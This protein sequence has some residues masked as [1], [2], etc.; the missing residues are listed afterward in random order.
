LQLES[1]DVGEFGMNTPA[2]VCLDTI[3]PGPSV[4]SFDDLEL[5]ADEVWN[6]SDGSNGFTS[7]TVSFSNNYNAE[8]DSW[9]GFA[10]SNQTDTTLEGLDGQYTAIAGGG[11]AGT[12]NYA[13]AYVGWAEPPTMTVL[14]PQVLEGLYVTNTNYAYYAMR[15][16][17]AF[18]K[19][20]GGDTGD[21]EDWFK[22]VVTGYDAAGQVTGTVEFYLAD[23]RFADNSLDYIVDT[24]QF[25]DL[26]PLGVVQSLQLQLESSDVGEFGMNTP[27]YVC[28]DT[29]VP[30]V[31][32]NTDESP[33]NA[34]GDENAADDTPEGQ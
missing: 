16:G 9:D 10:Y 2:Y 13:V 27:A 18:A 25:V 12:A 14:T 7:G 24:W 19:K 3:V 6:G 28:L 15:N 22:L 31:G 4:T 11:Q 30:A 33:D 1:S 20:F 17:D 5:P 34:D 8:W 26:R 21:D 32:D 23:F 29:I